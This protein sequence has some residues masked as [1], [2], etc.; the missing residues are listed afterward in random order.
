MYNLVINEAYKPFVTKTRL[1]LAA[2]EMVPDDPCA[3][4]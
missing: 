2:S 1:S 3:S 4:W